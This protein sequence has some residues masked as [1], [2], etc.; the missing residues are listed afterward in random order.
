M[1][2]K[3]FILPFLLLISFS[4]EASEL[5]LEKFSFQ[6]KGDWGVHSNEN[7]SK[8]AIFKGSDRKKAF[9]LSVFH[10]GSQEQALKFLVDI[11]D[12]ITNLDQVNNSLKV[13]HEYSEYKTKSGAPFM[14]ITYSDKNNKGF[15]I[16]SSLGSSAGILMITYEGSGGH[17]D[18]VEEFKEILESMKIEGE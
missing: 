10:P 2:Y 17:K 9:I 6:L 5:T 18:A 13:E 4:I 11:Q 3:L 8:S 15:F 16:G 1:K 7:G 14:Y 12:Y